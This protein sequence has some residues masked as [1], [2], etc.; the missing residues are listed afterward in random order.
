M[1]IQGKQRNS[2]WEGKNLF[3]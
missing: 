2:V 1:L 3:L